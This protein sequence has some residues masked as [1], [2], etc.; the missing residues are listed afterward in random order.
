MVDIHSYSNDS[1]IYGIY[2][3]NT[4]VY[5]GRA[6]NFHMRFNAHTNNIRHEERFWYP[7]AREFDKRGHS[8]VAKILETV[9]M[10]N[11]VA[12]ELDYIIKY[13]PIFN[14]EGCS[15]DKVIPTDYN[16]AVEI[17]GISYHPPIEEV[18]IE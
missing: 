18:K 17:L 14:K 4:L 3:D 2:I 15:E 1:G 8:I 16:A 10:E 9:P 13:N 6:K 11:I 5:V 12:K 7:L